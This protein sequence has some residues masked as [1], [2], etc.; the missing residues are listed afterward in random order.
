VE[1]GC[2]ANVSDQHTASIGPDDVGSMFL[3]NTGN[4]AYFQ[5]MPVP[6][7]RINIKYGCLNFW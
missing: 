7:S 1:V 4:T 5:T 6:K 3:W 2:V